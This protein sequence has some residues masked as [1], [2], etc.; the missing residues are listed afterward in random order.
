M[1][2]QE[3][4]LVRV[5]VTGGTG[6]VGPAAVAHLVARG[7]EVA[8]VG[9]RPGIEIPGADYA[10]CDVTSYEAVRDAM[11]GRDAAVHLAAAAS[12]GQAPAQELFRANALG[13]FHVFEAAAREGIR[14][15]VQASSI[16]ALGCYWGIVPFTPRYFPVDEEH[17]TFTTDP[18]SFSKNVAE[19]IAH[20]CWR[21]DGI[22]SV[23]LRLPWV[24][25]APESPEQA[26]AWRRQ[27]EKEREILDELVASP[28]CE[29]R[30]RLA[31]VR[32]WADEYRSLRPSEFQA[33]VP[34][35]AKARRPDDPLLEVYLGRFDLWTAIDER[36][37]AQAIEKGLTAT[38][39]G[40]HALFVNARD[41]WLGYDTRTLARLFFPEVAQW[42]G[43]V[44]GVES[45][46]SI[47]KA[48]ELIG[49]EPQH[50]M[51]GV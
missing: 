33:R 2:Y 22:T 34:D 26:A 43:A 6:A 20:Y 14:R 8:V 9:R 30:K 11:R 50:S 21:R 48:R 15:V 10:V 16:N 47:A 28:E 37:S 39:D 3:D 5:L 25:Q 4:P 19:D 45:L 24:R 18:Y 46:V 23:S 42:K 40:S 44:S 17:P 12:P 27:R 1:A 51:A 31:A 29:R 36:D 7:H 13:T 41:N 38:Y 49:F 32:Q 35:A